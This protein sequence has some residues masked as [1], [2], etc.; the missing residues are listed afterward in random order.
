MAR[1]VRTHLT[2]TSKAPQQELLPKHLTKQE[3]G[4]RLYRMMLNKGWTQSELSRQAGLPRDS[5]SV[6]VRGRSLPTPLNAE[7]LA[8]AFGVSV[9]DILPNL[10]ESAI[11]EDQPAFEMR[12]SVNAPS[13]VWLRINRAVS[14]STAVKVAELLQQDNVAD[15]G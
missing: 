14:L 6:Y 7:K 15:R 4:K 9:R 1:K 5:I 2:D 11:D 12:A 3:F 10:V 8:R 13:V